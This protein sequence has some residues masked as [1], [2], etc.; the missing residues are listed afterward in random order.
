M[1]SLIPLLLFIVGLMIAGLAALQHDRAYPLGVGMLVIAGVLAFFLLNIA[2]IKRHFRF[3]VEKCP[4]KGKPPQWGSIK[5]GYRWYND[6]G[7][8]GRAEA[9]CTRCGYCVPINLS[10]ADYAAGSA[11][12]SLIPLHP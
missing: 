3:T 9:S 11:D 8:R 4:E 6:P 10:P 1:R 7:D 2:N 12:P 5:R